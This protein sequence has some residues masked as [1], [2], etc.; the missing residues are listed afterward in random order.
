MLAAA[1]AFGQHA[2]E[3][4]AGDLRDR[5]PHRDLDGADADRALGVAADLFALAHGG[6]NLRRVEIVAGL[7]EQR[8]RVGAQDARDESLAHLVRRTHS[9]RSS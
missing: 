9:G 6:Q 5:V 3:R 2:M 1:V 8:R 7:V 4:L